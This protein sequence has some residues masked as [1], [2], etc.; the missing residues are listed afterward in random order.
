MNC[1]QGDVAVVVRSESGNEGKIVRC[2]ECVFKSWPFGVG[3]RW[4]TDPPL[5]NLFYS[6]IPILDSWLKP[7]RDSE[8]EDEMLRIAGFPQPICETPNV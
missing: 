7:L 6:A 5:N 3:P 4:V 8:G 1:K 2:L